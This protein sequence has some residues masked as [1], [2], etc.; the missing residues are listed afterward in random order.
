MATRLAA[1]QFSCSWDRAKNIAKA[2]DMVRE[3]AAKEADLVLLPELFETPYFCQDQSADHYAL[4]RTFEDNPL[5]AE[6]SVLAKE[7]S[8]VLPLSFFERAH[9]AYYNSL[10]IIDRDGRLLGRYRKSHIPDGPGYQEKFY[11]RPGD[12]GFHVWTTASGTLGPAICWDQWFPEAARILALEGADVLLYPTAIGSE[13]PPATPVDSRD[14]W[15]RVMQGHAAANYVPV[16]AANRVGIE[17]GQ[18]SELTFY[19]SSFIAGPTGEIVAELDREEEGVITASFD[20]PA[21]AK[22][23]ASWGLFRDR[24][25]DLYKPLLTGDGDTQENK[26]PASVSSGR[27]DQD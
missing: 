22:A 26:T 25:P 14:H 24:R 18:A 15:R 21:I 12:T 3:A 6:F 23:R 10:A 1:A 7:L 11:F 4:A 9:N 19:G 5:I 16:V 8:V 20:F 17:K 13:P 2:K 27:A